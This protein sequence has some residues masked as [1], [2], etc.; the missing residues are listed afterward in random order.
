M[1][2]RRKD[3]AAAEPAVVRLNVVQT[4][5][6]W[7]PEGPGAEGP[8]AYLP[9]VIGR[10]ASVELGPASTAA[11]VVARAWGRLEWDFCSRW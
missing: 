4:S 5:V 6:E 8:G 1:R 7:L 3:D 9:L 10:G 11:L 2:N